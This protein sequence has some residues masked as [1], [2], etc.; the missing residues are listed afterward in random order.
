MSYIDLTAYRKENGLTQK[1]LAK[2]IGTSATYISNIE[3]G[4]SNISQDKLQT[5]LSL[6]GY[7]TNSLLPAYHRILLVKKMGN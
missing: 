1:D 6:E 5:L 7:D 2:L 3:N 4:R